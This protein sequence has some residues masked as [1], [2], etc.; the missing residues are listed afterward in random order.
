MSP[1]GWSMRGSYFLRGTNDR[2][3][4]D[5]WCIGTGGTVCKVGN[6]DNSRSQ[7]IIRIDMQNGQV[8]WDPSNALLTKTLTD[9]EVSRILF[10]SSLT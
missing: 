2:L 1:V 6:L 3:V 10:S 8:I 7:S 9:K 5:Q 4:E